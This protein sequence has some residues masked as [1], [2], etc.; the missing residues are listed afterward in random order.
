MI[1]LNAFFSGLIGG[2]LFL[3]LCAPAYGQCPSPV[4]TKIQQ[5]EAKSFQANEGEIIFQFTEG[6]IPT[7]S[8]YRIRL[9]DQESKQFV[10]DD[11]HPAFL[12]IIPAPVVENSRIQFTGLPEG[13]YVLLLHGGACDQQQYA[14]T[15]NQ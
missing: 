10:H 15:E 13:K 9:F 12:N 8:N 11:N 1:Q 5:S 2:F 3:A 4:H 7:G 14:V 6:D